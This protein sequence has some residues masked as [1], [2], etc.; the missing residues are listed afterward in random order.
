MSLRMSGI[1]KRFGATV[2]LDGVD[3]TVSEGEVL[4]LV[5]ENGAGKSTLMKI[6]SGAISPDEGTI[7]LSGQAFHP[8]SPLDARRAGIG[9]IYQELSLAPHL[10]V[11]ENIC[12]GEEPG[13]S[14]FV[15]WGA[16]RR[17]A[18]EALRTLGRTDIDVD[19]IC[20]RL[21]I[22]SQQLVEIARAVALGSRVLVLDEPTSSLGREDAEHLFGLVRRL[23]AEGHV[24]VYISHFLEEVRALSDRYMVLRDGRTVGQGRTSE[25]TEAELVA[26]MVGRDVHELYP[27]SART[28]G[29]LVLQIDHLRGEK[30]PQE[31]S[32]MLHE[33]EVVG[34]AGVVGAGRT[35][36]L[37][38]IFGLDPMVAGSIDPGGR[39]F[40]PGDRWREGMGL[41]S[42]DRKTEGLA[43]DL[44]IA[45]NLMLPS[46]GRV[47]KPREL[48]R[49]ANHWADRMQV[50]RQSVDQ[51]VRDLSGGNQ[52]K[53]A[54]ARLLGK[55]SQVLLLDEPTRGIDI[56][57]KAQIYEVI[58][59][60]A[61]SGKAVLV[62]S[63][64]LPEL[65]GICDRIG[66]M[67]RG[68]LG[69][70][71]PVG[72]WDEHR[73]MQAATGGAS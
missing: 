30:G 38:T 36:M 31:A 29:R 40:T 8:R 23:R 34:I 69:P 39:R 13:R 55:D 50:R 28:P 26:L 16:M 5:G 9:V 1:R 56:G 7:E 17:T 4:A 15:D 6:L 41:V 48:E 72:E 46:L 53:V 35:E 67:C 19:A 65:M 3:L 2:A 43:V 47:V 70:V 49:M 10:T 27:R 42:E 22:A 71:R 54:I 57:S 59:A 14:G 73:I 11:A 32:L 33:G 44:T 52:Q 58:D 18:R 62:V 51:P 45:D 63:S 12:L 20:A 61:R 66:V 68:V 24:V 25:V 60:L 64:Y 37:R 21:P